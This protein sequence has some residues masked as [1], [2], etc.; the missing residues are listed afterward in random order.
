MLGLFSD[1]YTLEHAGTGWLAHLL[2]LLTIIVGILVVSIAIY[3]CLDQLGPTMLFRFTTRQFP[4]WFWL[5]ENG[6]PDDFGPGW[7][8]ALAIAVAVMPL[9]VLFVA[10]VNARAE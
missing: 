4:L 10:V 2:R 5:P 1:L 3:M 9:L 7:S 8:I 6:A